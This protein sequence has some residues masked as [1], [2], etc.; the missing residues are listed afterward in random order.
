MPNDLLSMTL[1]YSPPSRKENPRMTDTQLAEPAAGQSKYELVDCDVHPIMR[2]GM[3]D[4]KPF[5]SE[6][7]QHRLGIDGRRGLTTGG[8]REAVSIPRNMVYVNPA[9][10]LRGDAHSPDGA[11][12][13]ADPAF[14]AQQLLDTHGIDRAVL[15]GGEV[16]GLGAMP[17]PDAAALIASAYNDWLAA[18]WLGRRRP[19]PRHPRR[20]G[21]GS[22]ARGQGDPPRR[23][24]RA[25]RRRP[26]AAD[27]HLD[28]AAALLPDLRGRGRVRAADHRAPQLRRGHLPY[29]AEHGRRTA[30]VLRR[31]AHRAQPGLPGQPDQPGLP[32]RVRAVPEPQGGHHRRRARLDP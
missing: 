9:G 20:R 3:A 4:L 17:D 8:Q 26:D 6:A 11:Y 22:A 15:I 7:G 18:T 2:G 10:V 27:Q 32:R 16:L 24:R 12:P 5:L 30:D 13:G 19:L 21:A 14:T 29:L 25:V 31:V 28:G 1:T 23:E